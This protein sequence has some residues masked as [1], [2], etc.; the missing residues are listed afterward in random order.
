MAQVVSFKCTLRNRSGQ[1]ISSSVSH[2]VLTGAKNS[3]LHLRGLARGLENLTKGERRLIEVPAQDAYGFYDPTKVFVVLRRNFPELDRIAMGE[4]IN[5]Q[6][7]NGSMV[8]SRVLE[9]TAEEITLDGNHPLAGQDLVF[10]I[11]TL[12]ARDAR[13]DELLEIVGPVTPIKMH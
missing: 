1:F 13:P 3:D 7:S 5:L 2:D 6:L 11:E 12:D 10:E 9:F 4:M 8:E